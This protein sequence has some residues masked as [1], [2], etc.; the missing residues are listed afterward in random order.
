MPTKMTTMITE[1][2]E[3]LVEAGAPKEKAKQ[4]AESIAVYESRFNQIESDLRLVKW[5]LSLIVAGVLAL[6]VKTF[7][8]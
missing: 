6:V 1:V 4:A 8:V 5:M 7:F 2:Y 3:A